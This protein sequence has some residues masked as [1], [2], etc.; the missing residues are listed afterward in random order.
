MEID[1][2][3]FDAD[4]RF[5]EKTAKIVA[6]REGYAAKEGARRHSAMHVAAFVLGLIAV[7]GN[8][9]WYI[10][11]PCGILAIVFGVKSARALAS[12]LG[13]AGFILGIIG[14]ALTVFIYVSI[15]L[16]L[17]HDLYY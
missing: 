15:V 4:G 8:M 1:E 14:I 16:A 5:D 12:R 11:I 13:K 10:S 17:T 6:R 3:Q 9:F 7:I 2:K